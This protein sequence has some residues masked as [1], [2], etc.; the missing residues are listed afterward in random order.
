MARLLPVLAIAA[1]AALV[2]GLLL[3]ATAGG[4]VHIGPVAHLVV[5]GVAGALAAVAA[6]ALSV[7]AARVNDSRV[8]VLGTA[9]S[10]MATMLVVHAL[11]TPGV[12]VGEHEGG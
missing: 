8:V 6:S 5:V 4:H 3:A 12:W 2:P 10:V 11:S 1:A 9:F 7:V